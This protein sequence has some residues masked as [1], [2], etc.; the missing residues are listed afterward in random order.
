MKTRFSR[1][2]NHTTL[3]A[4]LALFLALG[5]L[6][7]AA[8]KGHHKNDVTTRSATVQLANPTCTTV[9]TTT[10]CTYPAAP[11]TAK[12]KK[13][14]HAVGGGY[15]GSQSGAPTSSD[16]SFSGVGSFNRPDPV[17]GTPTGWSAEGVGSTSSPD[18]PAPS[19]TVYAVCSS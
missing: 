4:C 2:P 15:E 12:C 8:S 3:I 9:G 5:G 16:Y 10:F 14:E 7:Y 1:L 17:K 19:F 18:L 11:V 13:G 6:S